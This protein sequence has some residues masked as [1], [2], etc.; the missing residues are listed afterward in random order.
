MII[1]NGLVASAFATHFDDDKDVIVFASGVSNSREN[2]AE[3]FLREDQMLRKCLLLGK[4]VIYFSTCSVD[5]PS[6]RD[7]PY[8]NHK[9]Q[10]EL[11]V[12]GTE[13]YAIFRLP[14]VVGNTPN[15]NTLTNYLYQKI[16]SGATFELWRHAR[17][18]LID[19]D[20]VATIVT[21]LVRSALTHQVTENIVSP[22]SI[23][24]PQLV[25]DFELVLGVT[26]NY[27]V[28]DAGGTYPIDSGLAIEVAH[29]SG[30]NFDECY[31]QK[32]I[33]KYYGK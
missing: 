27:S 6:L 7:T 18:N 17:R 12:S 33:R 1:G 8:V 31:I 3:E 9:K 19:V 23:S 14:Q 2:R 15:P 32:I 22:F 5:D 24:M 28:V 20:D 10:M 26:A 25:R 11:L 21:Y 29:R 13:K 4:F 30:V 16:S